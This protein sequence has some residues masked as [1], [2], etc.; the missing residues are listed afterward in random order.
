MK[1]L[2][3]EDQLRL[4]GRGGRWLESE[5]FC[6][7]LEQATGY[8]IFHCQDVF[9]AVEILRKEKIDFV[10]TD[11][12]LPQ[13]AGEEPSPV[14][15]LQIVEILKSKKI[16][17]KV[18]TSV[19]HCAHALTAAAEAGLITAE[20]SMWVQDNHVEMEYAASAEDDP[21][22][23]PKLDRI[24]EWKHGGVVVS[25]CFIV[26]GKRPVFLEDFI[27]KWVKVISM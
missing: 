11:M 12:G 25:G 27:K 14:A 8:E 6:S 10:V 17:F 22:F 3:V 20:W 16:P 19:T 7:L 5:E 23:P 4:G 21:R 2:I 15:G 13:M 18:F 1:V 24:G 26:G 9:S